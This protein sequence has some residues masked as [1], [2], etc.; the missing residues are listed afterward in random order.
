MTEQAN[1]LGRRRGAR[2][3][4]FLPIQSC[5][6]Y[7]G[8]RRSALTGRTVDVSPSGIRLRLDKPTKLGPGEA[9]YVRLD[10]LGSHGFI[11]VQGVVR[12]VRPGQDGQPWEMGVELTGMALEQW[13][14]WLEVLPPLP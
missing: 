1:D 6:P 11:N 8:K 12:W 2:A 4:V 13:D 14:K 10:A 3:S 7:G 5:R 9:V